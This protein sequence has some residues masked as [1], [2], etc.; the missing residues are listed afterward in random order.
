M[1][2]GQTIWR[3]G[4][5]LVFVFLGVATCIVVIDIITSTGV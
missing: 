2:I 5:A 1:K 3:A 4:F